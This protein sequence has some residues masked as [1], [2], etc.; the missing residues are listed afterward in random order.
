MNLQ[1]DEQRRRRQRERREQEERD[2]RERLRRK[3]GI[4]QGL[5]S[6]LQALP[7]SWWAGSFLSTYWLA[8]P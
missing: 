7:V 1:K 2:E 5:A 4:I 6:L 3:E 8:S